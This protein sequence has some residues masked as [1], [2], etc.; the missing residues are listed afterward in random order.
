MSILSTRRASARGGSYRP[1]VTVIA[2]TA[3]LV[4]VAAGSLQ[5]G[6]IMVIDPTSPMG[7]SLDHLQATPFDNYFWPGMFLL[8]IALAAIITIPGLLLK[9][10]WRWA[11][12][13]ESL[14]GYEWPWVS[15][16][17]IGILLFSFEVIGLVFGELPFQMHLLTVA[18]SLN[19]IGLALTDS[20]RD[21]LAS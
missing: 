15:V 6:I 17:S 8:G 2:L 18:L 5:G 11:W 20:A 12:R 21:Y 3:L 4:L 7:I 16:L 1:P 14:I 9:W 10:E 13:I 19:M